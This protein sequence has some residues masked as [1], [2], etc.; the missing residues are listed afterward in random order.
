[1]KVA[2]RIQ[3]STLLFTSQLAIDNFEKRYNCQTITLEKLSNRDVYNIL[4]SKT[5]SRGDILKQLL[6]LQNERNKDGIPS[7]VL[8]LDHE[9]L[10]F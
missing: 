2:Q 6:D 10:R 4:S 5:K 3:F 9:F 7:K 8:D 1:M